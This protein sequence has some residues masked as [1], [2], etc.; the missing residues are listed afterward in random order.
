MTELEISKL[1]EDASRKNKEKN[2]MMNSNGVFSHKSE[3][4]NNNYNYQSGIENVL[5][6]GSFSYKLSKRM[7]QVPITTRNKY[8]FLVGA[9]II[10]LIFFLMVI[11]ITFDAYNKESTANTKSVSASLKAN[12][13]TIPQETFD[14]TTDMD[15]SS[16]Y[17]NVQETSFEEIAIPESIGSYMNTDSFSAPSDTAMKSSSFI[18]E[19]DSINL[20]S[21]VS[22]A[23]NVNMDEEIQ[24][25]RSLYKYTNDNQGSYSVG[26]DP[27]N[28]IGNGVFYYYGDIPVKSIIKNGAFTAESYYKNPGIGD[29]VNGITSPEQHIVFV[30]AYDTNGNEYRIYFKDQQII[31]Y[32]GPDH[33]ENDNPDGDSIHELLDKSASL[34]GGSNIYTILS[35]VVPGVNIF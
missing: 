2:K 24:Y 17:S 23:L 27:F 5:E 31:R 14:N 35:M 29:I 13:E 8:I 15:N 4:A 9:A 25:I 3:T 22:S 11:P 12:E 10:S 32:I 1:V 18:E 20:E 28:E 26:T 19:T 30:F 7:E 21:N 6:P 16:V 33:V 34:N